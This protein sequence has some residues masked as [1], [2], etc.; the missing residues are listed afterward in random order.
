MLDAF[1]PSA[2]EPNTRDKCCA[3]THRGADDPTN[4]E[5]QV[6]IIYVFWRDVDMDI[7]QI[8]EQ[9][10]NECRAFPDK[11]ELPTRMK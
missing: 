10:E 9:R 4:W 11:E 1:Y 7:H 6:V 8:L 2:P 5:K 3:N